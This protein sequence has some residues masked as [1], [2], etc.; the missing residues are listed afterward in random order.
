MVTVGLYV[1]L[2][3]RPG[4]EQEVASFLEGALPL[5]NDEPD[6]TAWFGIKLGPSTYAVFD[7]FENDEGRDAHLNGKVA[8]ALMEKADE[9]FSEPPTIEKIDVLAAKLP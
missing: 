9:L 6:T 1:R 7:V 5:V 2:E 4:K 3:A 8:A